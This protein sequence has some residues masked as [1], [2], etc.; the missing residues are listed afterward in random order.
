LRKIELVPTRRPRNILNGMQLS[1]HAAPEQQ[2]PAGRSY[3]KKV[4]SVLLYYFFQQLEVCSAPVHGK[5][6]LDQFAG[7]HKSSAVLVASS[8][9]F[10]MQQRQLLIPMRRK[11]GGF[12]KFGLQVF[13]AFFGD[14]ATLL[15]ASGFMLAAA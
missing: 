3:C 5:H 4:M 9:L 14:G 11:F 7:Y 6:V 2:G 13:V 15:F 8:K 1:A 12:N 10:L